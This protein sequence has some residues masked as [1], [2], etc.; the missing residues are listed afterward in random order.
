[1]GAENTQV[2]QEKIRTSDSPAAFL[3][4]DTEVDK[5]R[6]A[7]TAPGS[8]TASSFQLPAGMPS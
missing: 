3:K 4:I 2:L 6:C 1:M 5:S 7:S 8:K